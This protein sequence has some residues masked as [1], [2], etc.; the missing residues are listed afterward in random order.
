MAKANAVTIELF[1]R[2]SGGH[3]SA[4]KLLT[5]G[6]TYY[7]DCPGASGD[8]VAADRR[9]QEWRLPRAIRRQVWRRPRTAI[10]YS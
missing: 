4:H 7:L 5:V 2:N 1:I 9:V 10:E 3:K 8:R 6:I